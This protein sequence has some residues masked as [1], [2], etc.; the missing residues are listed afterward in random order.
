MRCLF[1]EIIIRGVIANLNI[2]DHIGLG[3]VSV[4]ELAKLENSDPKCSTDY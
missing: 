4:I 2:A 1:N 3:E